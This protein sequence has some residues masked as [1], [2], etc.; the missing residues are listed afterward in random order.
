M[1]LAELRTLGWSNDRV[2]RALG[3]NEAYFDRTLAEIRQSDRR[4]R[5]QLNSRIVEALEGIVLSVSSPLYSSSTSE[6]KDT[7]C[8]DL[9]AL[10]SG[11]VHT[12]LTI[13]PPLENYYPDVLYEALEAARRGAKLR[14][15]F[16]SAD[17]IRFA[18]H[19]ILCPRKESG[20]RTVTEE[21][22]EAE[23]QQ[24]VDL[25]T[26]MFGWLGELR[27]AFDL[28]LAR[29]G[30]Q[31]RALDAAGSKADTSYVDAVSKIRFFELRW[32]PVNLNEK[33]V[34]ITKA[35]SAETGPEHRI[36]RDV[37]LPSTL[38][39]ADALG[40]LDRHSAVTPYGD[41]QR[42][43]RIVYPAESAP[44]KA[45]LRSVRTERDPFSETRGERQLPTPTNAR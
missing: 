20:T 23:E 7:V 43:C 11:E 12:L 29:F 10:K 28:F 8:R 39:P 4:A 14:Y 3:L 34:W 9:R 40:Q 44:L 26:L 13:P 45:L 15:Y 36:Y 33:I 17:L 27:P 19:E 35:G 22:E 25:A 16:P 32:M 5:P 18:Q 30:S 1:A 21:E 24:A 42:W 38:S 6:Y 31:A 37:L 2:R 41:S